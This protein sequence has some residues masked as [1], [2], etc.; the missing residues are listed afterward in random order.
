[1][2]VQILVTAGQP[3]Q[4]LGNEVAQCV[5]DAVGVPRVMQGIGY[6]SR[7]ADPAIDLANQH[8]TAIRAECTPF[9]IGPDHP[10][11]KTPK[12]QFIRGTLWH[13]HSPPQNLRHTL[14]LCGFHDCADLMGG[15]ISGLGELIARALR[16]GTATSRRA[17]TLFSPTAEFLCPA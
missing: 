14:I 3:V 10:A 16:N 1:M 17:R 8:Q 11:P 6:R 5:G 2:I 12:I 15:E 7:E 13:R 9:E 4:A